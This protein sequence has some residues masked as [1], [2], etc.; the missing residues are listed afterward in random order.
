MKV[1]IVKQLERE[2]GYQVMI[3]TRFGFNHVFAGKLFTLEEAKE[4]CTTNGYNVIAIGDLWEC[5]DK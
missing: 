5:L 1:C 3:P 2:K 4:I